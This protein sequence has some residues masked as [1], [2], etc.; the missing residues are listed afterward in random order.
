MAREMA[1]DGS[2]QISQI[3]VFLEI[4]SED[5]VSGGKVGSALRVALSPSRGLR[6]R[7]VQP[8]SKRGLSFLSLSHN[9]HLYRESQT[10]RVASTCQHFANAAHARRT[11]HARDPRSG[12]GSRVDH[13]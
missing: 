1:R 11:P 10:T 5:L 13:A 3:S 4:S 7:F 6:F 12:F 2:F 9:R 8:R